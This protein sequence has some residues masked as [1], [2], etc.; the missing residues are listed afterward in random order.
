V[1]GKGVR[2]PRVT[3]YTFHLFTFT[4]SLLVH[5]TLAIIYA[6]FAMMLGHACLAKYANWGPLRGTA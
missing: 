1:H 4:S 5:S 6:N 3:R 2:V